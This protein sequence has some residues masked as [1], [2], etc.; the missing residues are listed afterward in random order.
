MG[1]YGFRLYKVRV[2]KGR[3]HKLTDFAQCGDRHY[4]DLANDLLASLQSIAIGDPSIN[5]KD[6]EEAESGVDD[7]TQNLAGK[8]AFKVER[9]KNHDR[10]ILGSFYSGKFGEYQLAMSASEEDDAS[11]EGLAASKS[12]RFALAFPDEGEYGIL[13]VEVINLACPVGQLIGWLNQRSRE[14][15]ILTA[16]TEGVIESQGAAWW[17]LRVQQMTDFE[18]LRELVEASRISK[19]DLVQYETGSDRLRSRVKMRVTAPFVEGNAAH[20]V[21]EAV[22]SWWAQKQAAE[23]APPDESV[24]LSSDREGAAELRAV[25]GKDIENIEFDDGWVVLKDAGD[26][27]KQISPSRMSELFTYPLSYDTAVS[28]E[29]FYNKVADRARRLATNSNVFV[30]W[31]LVR[32]V[33]R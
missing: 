26:R 10:V 12:Y 8:R 16:E 28:D 33:L 23:E 9:Y 14:L 22:K 29:V 27:S 4:Q 30:E 5:P 7:G 18:Q 19:V 21:I 13:G 2:H 15:A 3:A 20:V 32:D 11:L 25:F 6:G 31:P 24:Q 17:H 1:R